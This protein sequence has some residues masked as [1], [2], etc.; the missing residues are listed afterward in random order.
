MLEHEGTYSIHGALMKT[1]NLSMNKEGR[2][3]LDKKKHG[4]ILRTIEAKNWLDAREQVPTQ[5]FERKEG[6]GYPA[7]PNR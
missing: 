6:Y 4:E 3:V 7:E 1:F 2:L 5:Y